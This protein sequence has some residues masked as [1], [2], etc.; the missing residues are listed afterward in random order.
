LHISKKSRTFARKKQVPTQ[1]I[2]SSWNAAS[3]KAQG[4][5]RG[6]SSKSTYSLTPKLSIN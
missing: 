2:L 6:G 1:K 4:Y 5:N 3:N